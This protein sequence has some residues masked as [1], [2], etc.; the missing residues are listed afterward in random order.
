MF[1]LIALVTVPFTGALVKY[2]LAYHPK[3][4]ST[5]DPEAVIPRTGITSDT[6][7]KLAAAANSPSGN[8]SS[9]DRPYN[10]PASSSAGAPG[11]TASEGATTPVETANVATQPTFFSIAKRIYQI[12]GRGGF[13]KG[14]V[15]TIVVNFIT[16]MSSRNF[17]TRFYISPAPST[18]NR[19]LNQA[20]V[21][22]L[23]YSL[24]LVWIYR[25]IATRTR[26]EVF[27]TSIKDGIRALF[28]HFERARP[29]RVMTPS[30]LSALFG[31]ILL[32]KFI[33]DPLRWMIEPNQITNNIDAIYF[34]RL[35]ACLVLLLVNT[36]ICAPLDVIVTR[37]A[38][39]RN[40]GGTHIT[41][42]E[43]LG[44]DTS[45]SQVGMDKKS[46]PSTHEPELNDN[47]AVRYR[48]DDLECYTSVYDCAMKI[49]KEEGW[50]VLYR[51]WF[52]TFLGKVYS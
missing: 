9:G 33:F 30:L 38:V 34:L 6:E 19:T 24:A 20:L 25:S 5:P 23:F 36:L 47:L 18:F 39:Q 32:Q 43:P 48:S 41:T 8:M 45:A 40:Y 10:D 1:F 37:L 35:G 3:E 26:L 46:T 31:Q 14:I 12:E 2:R 50:T 28:T 7:N 27:G 17:M 11:Q 16:W 49:I 4:A 52:I 29:Y 51:G 21:W 15:P 22:T 44:T 13:Y 42:E